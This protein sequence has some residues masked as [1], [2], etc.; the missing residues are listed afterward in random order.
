MQISEEQLADILMY[1]I[2]SFISLQL[3][4]K[5]LEV[6]DRYDFLVKHYREIVSD[7]FERLIKSHPI[8]LH[9][10]K[11]KESGPYSKYAFDVNH[12]PNLLN[13]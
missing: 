2:D 6:R 9:Q 8:Y 3:R 7:E 1:I 4:A 5:N 10:I 12:Q 11:T 13:L